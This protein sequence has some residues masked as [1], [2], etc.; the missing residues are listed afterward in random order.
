M[1]PPG[2]GKRAPMN[3]PDAGGPPLVGVLM[4]SRSDWE[5][6]RHATETLA[7]LGVAHEAKVISAHRTPQRLQAYAEAARDRGLKVLS[8]VAGGAAHLPCD[9][10]AMTALPLLCVPI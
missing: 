6:M 3:Q 8:A 7:R 4:G 1:P 9:L 2:P 10:A 5:T